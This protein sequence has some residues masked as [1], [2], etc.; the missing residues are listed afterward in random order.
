MASAD[1]GLLAGL[2]ER[3]GADVLT[4]VRTLPRQAVGLE[5]GDDAAGHGVVGGDDAVDVAVVLGV[6]TVERVGSLVGVP[7][8]AHVTDELVGTRVELGLQRLRV[9]LLE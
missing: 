2:G 3:S 8:T 4:G 1:A 5:P 6:E 7:L 9:A